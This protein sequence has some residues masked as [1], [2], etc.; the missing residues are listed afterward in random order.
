MRKTLHSLLFLLFLLFL[1]VPV[2]AQKPADTPAP[3]QP[4]A[5]MAVK[6]SEVEE[7]RIENLKLKLRLYT[8]YKL[9]LQQEED[10]VN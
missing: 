1:A 8:Q 7:L 3:A 10:A 4:A 9:E 2:I 6:P 5:A